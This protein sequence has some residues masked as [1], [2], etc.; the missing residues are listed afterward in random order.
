MLV[1]SIDGRMPILATCHCIFTTY[2]WI[3]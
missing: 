3:V 2:V 1:T